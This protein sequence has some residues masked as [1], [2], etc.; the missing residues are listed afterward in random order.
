MATFLFWNLNRKPLEHLLAK[1]AREHS[2]DVL[3]LA[4]CEIGYAALLEALNEGQEPKYEMATDFTGEEV[5]KVLSI[6]SRDFIVPLYDDGDISIRA[7]R[8]PKRE[9]ILLASAHLPSKLHQDEREQLLTAVRIA[10]LIREYEN[11]LGHARTILVGDLNMAPFEPGMVAADA[12]HAVMSKDIALKVSRTVRGE[13]RPY[14][15]NPMWG[16]LGD[17]PPGPP[18]TYY[19]NSG[20]Q[21]NYFWNSFDQVLLRPSLLPHFRNEDLMV[22]TE[23]AGQSLLTNNGLPDKSSA[24][25]HLPILFR[26]SL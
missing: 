5:V 10:A 3:L 25:D 24:S 4:E 23:V 8:L 2:A 16:Q 1:M 21:I 15:F 20:K 13:K 12:F 26:L 9:E 22:L 14:F 19:Y 17:A 11:Q 7:L 6:F 18:G